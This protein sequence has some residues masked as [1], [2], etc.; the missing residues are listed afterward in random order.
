[1]IRNPLSKPGIILPLLLALLL[2]LVV[3][4][5][6]AATATPP[7]AEPAAPATQ[8]TPAAAVVEPTKAPVAT[9]IPNVTIR[10][11]NTPRP[12]ATPSVEATPTPSGGPKYGGDINMRAYADT[13]DWD[14]L[15]SA[16][17]SSVISYS[18]LYNQVVQYDTVNT[19][20]VIGD[21]AKS[22]DISNGGKTF[23]FH[24]NEDVK[25]HDGED[26]T[27]D[28]VVFALSRYYNPEVSIG[29]S[30]LTRNYVKPVDQGGIRAIDRNTVE[31]N[32][33]FPS[34][35]FIKFLAIDYAKILPKHLLEQGIDL[36]QG[37]NVI[38]H[39][40]GSGPFILDEYQRGNFY[41]VSKNPNYF[42]EG[43]P[44]FDSID[45]FIITDAS[46]FMSAFKAGQIDM[47]NAGGAS[48]TPVQ[49]A[50]LEEDMKGEVVAHFL[51]PA[52]NVGL[53]INVKKP[54]FDDPRIRK[55]IYLAIDRQQIND[56]V[57]DG[58]AGETTIFMPGMAYT[59]EDA[60]TW[61]GVRPKN[62]P[63]GQEDVAE[64]KRLMAEAGFADGIDITYDVRQVS[65]YVPT[66]QV[67]KEQ[68]KST[69]GIDG[70][71]R[72]WESA[73]G[74]KHYNAARSP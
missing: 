42:K 56:I 2:S 41:K 57:L 66:C 20:E 71:I 65:F 18:Q 15:G 8:P 17:L 43:R 50:Q 12:T 47:S 10:P 23:T 36:N 25:W 53:M 6:T 14:P 21:L 32:L 63:G 40:S 34:G 24:L 45:H 61:P 31:I 35:A 55:A 67:V 9:P 22:W 33:E 30:G 74:Y 4:C 27:A 1:M 16:S 64:A 62:T 68:L 49:N 70:D 60:L 37:E 13:R 54:P 3:A 58:T 39:K 11:T 72:T 69:L 38:Q 28:D 52:F 46:R 51:A 7:P 44:F 73:A 48:L 19:S 59:E 29:R 5:G 26:L